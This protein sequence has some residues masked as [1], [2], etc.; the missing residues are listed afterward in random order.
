MGV[1]L[2]EGSPEGEW[3]EDVWCP[4]NMYDRGD[5]RYKK[6]EREVKECRLSRKSEVRFMVK[7]S[8]REGQ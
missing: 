5:R 8:L 2:K 3:C 6:E 1:T 7:V 4:G